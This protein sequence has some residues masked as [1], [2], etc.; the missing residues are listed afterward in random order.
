MPPAVG[1]DGRLREIEGKAARSWGLGGVLPAQSQRLF[2]NSGRKGE[3]A[4]VKCV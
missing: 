3:Q 1:D 4:C 2:S